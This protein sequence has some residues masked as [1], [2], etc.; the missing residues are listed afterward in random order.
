[1]TGMEKLRNCQCL[2]LEP[3]PLYRLENVR[4]DLED[5]PLPLVCQLFLTLG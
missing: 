1:M 3:V 4:D 5:D 2:H